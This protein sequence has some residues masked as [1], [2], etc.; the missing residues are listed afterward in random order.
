MKELHLDI[1]IFLHDDEDF[2][3]H[4]HC[5]IASKPCNQEFVLLVFMSKIF[6]YSTSKSLIRN[7]SKN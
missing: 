7:S 5:A 1:V 6:M 3:T 4:I 2:Q